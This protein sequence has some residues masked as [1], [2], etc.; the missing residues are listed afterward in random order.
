MAYSHPETSV[1]SKNCA[2]LST[3]IEGKHSGAA[4][5]AH[6]IAGL[7]NKGVPAWGANIADFEVAL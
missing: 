4:E 6:R 1:F 5:S 7:G 2:A 3:K